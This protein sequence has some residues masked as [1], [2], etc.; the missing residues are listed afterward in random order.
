M[1]RCISGKQEDIGVNSGINWVDYETIA[2]TGE[3]ITSYLNIPVVL[4]EQH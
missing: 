1:D 3:S 2:I 4:D